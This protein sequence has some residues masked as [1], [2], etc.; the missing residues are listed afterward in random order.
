MQASSTETRRQTCFRKSAGTYW[1]HSWKTILARISW[2]SAMRRSKFEEWSP[3]L[4]CAHRKHTAWPR[5]QKRTAAAPLLPMTPDVYTIQKNI[6]TCAHWQTHRLAVDT[7]THRRCSPWPM[8]SVS[9]HTG[10]NSGLSWSLLFRGTVS[11]RGTQAFIQWH[12][13]VHNHKP[14]QMLQLKNRKKVKRLPC[15]PR[16]NRLWIQLWHWK[17]VRFI[18][19]KTPRIRRP[20]MWRLPCVYSNK[21]MKNIFGW[22][23]CLYVYVY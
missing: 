9:E 18:T 17:G 14:K 1:R 12:Q 20:H 16:L 23:V 3:A 15:S 13:F 11:R 6:N 7:E 21:K 19:K 4:R 8:T 5:M 10:R 22:N 2:M